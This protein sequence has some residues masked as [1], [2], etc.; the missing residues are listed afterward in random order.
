MNTKNFTEIDQKSVNAIRFLSIDAIEKANSG[1]PGLPLDAAPM[2]YVLWSQ[3]MKQNP[4]DSKWI[5][6]DRFILS[7]GHGSAML[8]SLLHFSGYKISL[9]DMKNFRQLG[10][11]TP[12]HPEYSIVDGADCTTG[13]L[14]QG[15]AMS[16]GMAMAEKHL[17]SIYNKPN[18]PLIDHF[19]FA[20][21]GD[22]CL[23]EGISHEAASLA[24]HLKLGKLIVLYDSNDVSLDGP[25][26]MAFTEDEKQ[27]FEGYGW[28]YLRVEDGNNLDEINAAI[29]EAKAHTSQPTI[30]EIKTIIGYGTPEAGTNAVH[31]APIG[32]KGLKYA[33]DFYSWN[34]KPFEIPSDVYDNF[35]EKITVVGENAENEWKKM[36]KSYEKNYPKEYKQFD[37]GLRDQNSVDIEGIIP[38]SEAG[39]SEATR[40]S[41]HRVINVISENNPNFWG[42]S[43]DLFSSNKTNSDEADNFEPKNYR[44]NNIWYGVREFAEGAAMNGIALH[45]GTKTYSSTFFV[46]SDYMRSAVRLSAIQHLPV[47]YVYTHDSIAVGEDG[48]THE[49]I[50]HLMSFRVMPNVNVLRPADANETVASWKIAIE[51]KST[52]TILVLSRQNLKTLPG[53]AKYKEVSRGAYVVSSQKSKEP[54]GILIAT[55]SEVNLALDAQAKLF[56]KGID[57]SVVSMPSFE[58][59]EK[60]SDEYKEQVLPANVKKRMSIEMGAT[61]GWERYVG[62][63]G[64]ALGIDQFGA[65]GKGEILIKHF[66]F[67]VDNVVDKFEV[68]FNS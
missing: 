49:P 51:S 57:V 38:T 67:T 19:T 3:H 15:L 13:P 41:S 48:L 64:F 63:E 6:R 10:S 8:Y 17:A 50:E 9:N 4:K 68:V 11:N 28:Q 43:A 36:V 56:E 26:S 37:A 12:G 58:L 39:E 32:E 20:L 7:A 40:N 29:T 52:P 55:G 47:T 21:T 24:G 27:R 5:N 42:G 59:F 35:K 61:L 23:M 54:Q 2:A 16:V 65:S 62:S 14:G 34:Y 30:I 33:R 46:F 25:T 22:G 18:M 44:G 60:Q 45:G 31:G 1:H 66:G 53:G